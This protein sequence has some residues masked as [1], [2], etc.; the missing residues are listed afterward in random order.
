[1]PF[2]AHGRYI[3]RA[4]LVLILITLSSFAY[5]FTMADVE[6]VQTRYQNRHA[7]L[8]KLLTREIGDLLNRRADL[9]PRLANL[10]AEE[11]VAYAVVQQPSGEVLAK[12]ESGL[13]AVESLQE[14][15]TQALQCAHLLLIQHEDLSHTIPLVEAAMPLVTENNRKVIVRVGFFRADEEEKIRQVRFRNLLIFSTLLL[16][17]ITFWFIRKRNASG[18]ST[19]WLGGTGLIVLLL[20]L[21][22]RMT[23]Q[24]WYERHWRQSFVQHGMSVAKVVSLAAKRF[25]KAGEEGDLREMQSLLDLDENYA[26]L[27]VAKDE[28]YLF[29]SD[30]QLKGAIFDPDSAYSRSLNSEMPIMVRM[31]EEGMYEVLVPIIEGQHRLGTLRLGLRNDSGHGPLGILRNRLTLIFLVALIISLLLVYL[32]SLRVSRD[33]GTF[34]QSMEQVTAGDLRQQVFIDRSDEFGQLAHAYN[35]MLMSLKERDLLGRGLQNYVSKSIVDKTLR[36]VTTQEKTGEKVFSVAIFAYF[37]GLTEAINR[38]SGP[39]VL[40]L[41]REF[42][43]TVR[44]VCQPGSGCHIQVHMAGILVLFAQQNR[45]EALM[46]A[47]QAAQMLDQSFLKRG[48]APFTPRLTLHAL[49]VVHGAIDDEGRDMIWLGEGM[50]DVRTFSDVQDI[51]EIIISEETS[52][53]LK[54][55]ATLDEFELASSDQ[56]RVRAYIFRGFKPIDTLIRIFPDSS[57]WTKVLILK[58]LKGQARIEHV[59]QLLQWFSDPD[60]NI[61]Y[62]VMDVLERLRPAG[63]LDF[64]VRTLNEE[65]EAKVLSKAISVLGKIGNEAH[66]PILAEKLRVDDRRVKANTVEALETI[67][68]KKVYEFLNLLVDEQDN[69][70]RANI[71][72]ALGKYGDLRVFELLTTMIKDPDRNMRASAAYALGKLGMAQGVEPLITALSDKDPMVRRQVVASLTALKAD[73]DI[74]S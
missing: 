29:H 11:A 55:V 51:D 37:S 17:L 27:A 41:V 14:I 15:E 13:V 65:A 20:F 73:L 10:L 6:E 53:L 60:P 28:Q 43:Q 68:G 63:I 19:A 64:V 8:I 54:D 59:D 25:L 69:R 70:V 36:M 72:I 35:F 26:F 48:E 62:H 16:G 44:Q 21:S 39:Q 49:E 42:Y 18:L 34:I 22:S 50:L 71:L 67:G 5:Y 56:G 3:E 24:E 52:F 66:V 45:H 12:A 40:A 23:I 58:I 9:T 61:R 32:L 47:V 38:N 30:P 74:D 31:P 4:F 2:K 1:M 46:Q 7:M 57:P 33:L